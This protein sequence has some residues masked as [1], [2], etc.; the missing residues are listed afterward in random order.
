MRISSAIFWKIKDG[1]GNV[2]IRIF[3][4]NVLLFT[5]LAAG[6]VLALASFTPGPKWYRGNMHTHTYWSDGDDFPENV[7][8]W[9]SQNNYDFLALTDHNLLQEGDNWRRF[10]ENETSMLEYIRTYGQ[11]QVNVRHDPDKQGFDQVRL[12]TFDELRRAFEKPDKFI[13][14]KSNE[15]SS[16]HAVHITGFNQDIVIPSSEG[17]PE[18]R[19]RMIKEVLQK[20]DDYRGSTG[21]KTMAV[22]AHPNFRWA[23]TAE[24]MLENPALRFFEVYNGHPQ[25]NNDGDKY[26]T[27]TE[28]IWDIVLS[29][30]L[31]GGN[32]QVIY[33]LATD[34]A[35]T[36]HGGAAGPGKGWV[37]VRSGKLTPESLIDAMNR[38]DFYAT[39]GVILKDIQFR[40]GTVKIEI[41]PAA[42]TKYVTEFIG[43]G[44][45]YD[46]SSIPTVDS[47]GK[48][49]QNTT[50]TYSRQIGEVFA[51]SRELNPSYTLT[52]N[53]LYVRVRITSD[54]DHKDPLNGKILGKQKAWVQPF[55]LKN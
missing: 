39:T 40:N 53:E 24:M 29:D 25:V 28:R 32:G 45:D 33:G 35:H 43:T 8:K 12:K 26:R 34:D 38:G 36:Y 44:K 47:A 3:F 16:Q 51:S 7:V 21:K 49:I 2:S 20:V 1:N 42:G 23:I 19:S 55:T 13:L 22:L 18:E 4:R 31:A 54:A 11:A 27:N 10:P 30:R 50:R 37:M 14:I 9:Y 6:A 15:I 41:Q 52:G 48:E 17:S 5:L 46:P